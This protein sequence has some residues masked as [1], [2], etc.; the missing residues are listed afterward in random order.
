MIEITWKWN[1]KCQDRKLNEDDLGVLLD[2]SLWLLIWKFFMFVVLSET[3]LLRRK[4]RKVWMKEDLLEDQY[5]RTSEV[6]RRFWRD[7]SRH[8]VWKTMA[9]RVFQYRSA[10]FAEPRR[11]FPRSFNKLLGLWKIS[12]RSVSN[13]GAMQGVHLFTVHNF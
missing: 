3:R 6:N 7:T 11:Y 8:D 5:Q 4:M 1:V 13:R 10:M 2:N 12:Y 9:L